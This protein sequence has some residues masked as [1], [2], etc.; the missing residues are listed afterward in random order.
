MIPQEI[1]TATWSCL[2]WVLLLLKPSLALLLTFGIIKQYYQC[3]SFLVLL[4]FDIATYIT[5]SSSARPSLLC[6]VD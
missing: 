6:P 1:K 2:L 4:L 5:S 3:S